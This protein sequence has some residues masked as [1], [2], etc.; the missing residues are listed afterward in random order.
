VDTPG[1]ALLDP[2]YELVS[3]Y[4]SCEEAGP[5]HVGVCCV[6][7]DVRVCAY[8][9]ARACECGCPECAHVWAC[10]NNIPAVGSFGTTK[11]KIFEF[12]LMAS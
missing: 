12:E 2:D 11:Q 6:C 5:Q 7:V 1:A 8:V 9:C 10:A 4:L 3:T